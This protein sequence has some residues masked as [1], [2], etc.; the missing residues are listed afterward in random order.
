MFLK[1]FHSL[2]FFFLPSG[3][4]QDFALCPGDPIKW[5][6]NWTRLKSPRPGPTEL[7]PHETGWVHPSHCF[8]NVTLSF[9]PVLCRLVLPSSARKKGFPS[10]A[11]HPLLFRQASGIHTHTHPALHTN[12]KFIITKQQQ[13]N[14]ATH[15]PPLT[16]AAS[17]APAPGIMNEGQSVESDRGSPQ[18]ARRHLQTAG[19]WLGTQR[20]GLVA[21]REL[22]RPSRP[23]ST[24]RSPP[25]AHLALL[26]LAPQAE[27][28]SCCCCCC[29]VPARPHRR[30]PGEATGSSRQRQKGRRG[31]EQDGEGEGGTEGEEE[32]GTAR[33]GACAGQS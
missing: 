25:S 6:K 11:I 10:S 31:A 23:A 17:L 16:L 8:P 24:P 13:L 12:G 1:V 27:R 33:T 30:A 21:R 9:F 5:W 18:P 22:S 20:A 7:G 15:F 14:Y 32:G 4:T 3:Q 29:T 19:W 26:E 2:A 28:P